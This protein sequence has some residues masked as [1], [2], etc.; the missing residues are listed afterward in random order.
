MPTTRSAARA[1]RDRKGAVAPARE[2]AAVA[3]MTSR[4]DSRLMVIVDPFGFA[5]L[6]DRGASPELGNA[7]AK[8]CATWRKAQRAYPLPRGQ[9]KGRPALAG[10]AQ[11]LALAGDGTCYCP[12]LRQLE[13]R[14]GKRA[15]LRRRS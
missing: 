6:V 2:S 13:Q 15:R 3:F 7:R 1:S 10:C 8:R 14:T 5:G 9:R 11:A 12:R 4:R